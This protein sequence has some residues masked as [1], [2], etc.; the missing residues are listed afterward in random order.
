MTFFKILTV[1]TMKKP[2]LFIVLVGIFSG[3]ASY[4]DRIIESDYSYSGK[5]SK[6]DTF[7]FMINHEAGVDA[8]NKK[9]VEKFIGQR[10]RSLGFI[11]KEK[12]PSLIVAYKVFYDDFNMK[13][14]AQPNFASYVNATEGDAKLADKNGSLETDEVTEYSDYF[15]VVSGGQYVDPND[16]EYAAIDCEMNEGSLLISFFDRKAKK[17]VWQGYASGVVQRMDEERFLRHTVGRILDDYRV[18]ASGFGL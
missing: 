5:F 12:K 15:N 8:K 3:C 18:L 6:Y 2:L 14:Y 1:D 10:M 7:D 11:Y 9:L 4:Y 16:L 17:T 13:G